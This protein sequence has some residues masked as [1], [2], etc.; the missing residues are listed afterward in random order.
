MASF[1]DDFDWDAAAVAATEIER[2][3][4]GVA[5]PADACAGGGRQGPG[6]PDPACARGAPDAQGGQA[7]ALG[8][9]QRKLDSFFAGSRTLSAHSAS[10]ELDFGNDAVELDEATASTWIYP[11]N[12]ERRDY[13]YDITERALLGNTLVCLPTGLGKT[14]VA[15]VVMYNFLRWF[16]KGKVVFVAPTR[17]LAGQQIKAVQRIMHF[18]EAKIVLLTGEVPPAERRHSWQSSSAF[19]LTPQTLQKDIESGSCPYKKVTCLI[20]D[21]AHHA[22]G[23][24]SARVVAKKLLN[25]GIG[26]RI[27]GLTAT[28]AFT[29]DKVQD[30]IDTLCISHIEYRSLQSVDVQ[31]YIHHKQ[32]IVH[33]VDVEEENMPVT[34]LLMRLLQPHVNVL[35]SYGLLDSRP[36]LSSFHSWAF[37]LAQKQATVAQNLVLTKGQRGDLQSRIAVCTSLALANERLRT[38]GPKAAHDLLTE[39]PAR[40][41]LSRVKNERDM[42]EAVRLLSL[43]AAQSPNQF[44]KM[45]KLEEVIVEHFQAHKEETRA[46]VFIKYR[47]S[48]TDIVHLLNKHDSIKAEKFIGQSHG[49]DKGQTQKEQKLVEERF[50]RGEFN[51]LVATSIGE[52][53]LDIAEVDLVVCFDVES[54]RSIIQR[55][56]RTGRKRQGVGMEKLKLSRKME[57]SKHTENLMRFGGQFERRASPRMIPFK[58][59]TP[60]VRMEH[61]K[62]SKNLDTQLKADTVAPTVDPATAMLTLEERNKL[63]AY[64][65]SD[66][67]TAAPYQ[68]CLNSFPRFQRSVTPVGKV[69]HSLRCRYMFVAILCQ[70]HGESMTEQLSKIKPTANHQVHWQHSLLEPR[71]CNDDI[72]SQ[73]RGTNT[74]D[75]LEFDQG[76]DQGSLWG[77]EGSGFEESSGPDSSRGKDGGECA[78]RREDTSVL[79][80]S[81]ETSLCIHISE[82]GGPVDGHGVLVGN[83]HCPGME[84]TSSVP[85]P[86]RLSTGVEQASEVAVA[87]SSYGWPVDCPWMHR[88][89]FQ[90]SVAGVLR[91]GEVFIAEPLVQGGTAV[92]ARSSDRCPQSLDKSLS[93]VELSADINCGIDFTQNDATGHGDPRVGQLPSLYLESPHEEQQQAREAVDSAQPQAVEEPRQPSTSSELG[94]TPEVLRRKG[95]KHLVVVSS[96]S[97]NLQDQTLRSSQDS[98]KLEIE[99]PLLT[100]KRLKRLRR[101]RDSQPALY[102]SSSQAVETDRLPSLT[103]RSN[104]RRCGREAARHFFDEEA[105]ISDDASSEEDEDG[106]EELAGFINDATP[107]ECAPSTDSKSSR[108]HQTTTAIDMMAVYRRSLLSQSPLG[109]GEASQGNPIFSTS[110]CQFDNRN[111]FKLRFGRRRPP[112]SSPSCEDTRAAE[113]GKAATDLEKD[114]RQQQD[115]H[116]KRLNT[117]GVDKEDN[118]HSDAGSVSLQQAGGA[119]VILELDDV[120]FQQGPL[121]T[122]KGAL[123]NHITAAPDSKPA[124][125]TSQGHLPS[126]A[127]VDVASLASPAK[128]THASGKVKEKTMGAGEVEALTSAE[129][130]APWTWG[131]D[132]STRH[133]TSGAWRYSADE[134]VCARLNFEAMECETSIKS[135]RR[136][137]VSAHTQ[138]ALKHMPAAG[139]TCMHSPPAPNRRNV[140]KDAANFTTACTWKHSFGQ[141]LGAGNQGCQLLN[142]IDR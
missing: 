107:S 39:K 45:Q 40:N 30:I 86:E 123:D 108:D 74:Y 14:F 102:K 94:G 63:Q 83:S 121:S 50:R 99:I 89:L 103:T 92:Q 131:Q 135:D 81:D 100:R 125:S 32:H 115:E 33:E 70:L 91:S 72:A 104:H 52:E 67:S 134:A 142:F 28:P 64:F 26:V 5:A 8:Q 71:A 116:C 56:G 106:V 129:G 130:D 113:P 12:M 127:A 47:S 111:A 133:L 78:V 82:E 90:S 124:P 19:F 141:Y 57:S 37:V 17:P 80:T 61:M 75:N 120:V 137:P 58:Y 35:R 128:C 140:W 15:A 79:H 4:F 95:Y 31:K 117:G 22:V 101:V 24:N 23:Q 138:L 46:M 25:A 7:L 96:P 98:D 85:L 38:H 136:L 105:E 93:K 59:G 21:E 84:Q 55:M 34:R 119:S 16:P 87:D 65:Q 18:P 48:V 43:R 69:E 1:D 29:A 44:P 49:K 122:I 11:A 76:W 9:D 118:K 20:V 10:L 77:V 41:P 112:V 66:T 126:H 3:H 13:Q 6:G 51:V 2:A 42:Q 97:G 60:Q 110:P 53:G 139:E 114:V 73:E 88:C 62:I 109:S 54:E 27:V 132:A 68:P 36:D